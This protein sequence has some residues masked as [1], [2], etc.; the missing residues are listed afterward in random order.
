MP[1]N[2]LQAPLF[3][4]IMDEHLLFFLKEDKFEMNFL[5]FPYSSHALDFI[6][7][8]CHKKNG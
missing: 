8:F 4:V 1:T 5:K 2:G 3:I 6:T 7:I